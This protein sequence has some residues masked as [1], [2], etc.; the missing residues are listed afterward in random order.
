MGIGGLFTANLTADKLYEDL[1]NLDDPILHKFWLTIKNQ[2]IAL[3]YFK[4]VNTLS[5]WSLSSPAS[6]QLGPAG[7][8]LTNTLTVIL[9]RANP[10]VE[11]TDTGAFKLEAYSDSGYT[12]LVADA[13]LNVSALIEDLENWID[14]TVTDFADGTAQGWTLSNLTVENDLS[15]EVGGYSL[16][17]QAATLGGQD[18]TKVCTASKSVTLPNTTKVRFLM[19]LAWVGTIS[20]AATMTNILKNI[21]LQVDGVKVFDIPFTLFSVVNVTSNSGTWLKFEGDLSDYANQTVTLLISFTL[22]TISTSTGDSSS[23]GWI[24]RIVVAGE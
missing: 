7:S 23:S 6:G 5:N 12:T 17:G 14:A 20:G 19:Y 4:I 10:G 9:S 18:I 24:G 22:E 1:T 11:V 3:L 2:S 16:K 15:V 8:G 21:S 13:T